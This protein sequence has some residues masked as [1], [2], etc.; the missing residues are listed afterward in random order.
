[1]GADELASLGRRPTRDIEAW[2]QFLKARDHLRNRKTIS[3]LNEALAHVAAAIERDPGFARAHSLRAVLLMLVPYWDGNS[4]RFETERGAQK[5]STADLQRQEA[6]WADALI[7]ANRALQLE[8]RLGEP[9]VVR[10]LF[11][12]RYNRYGDAD[13]DF[14]E[15]IARAPGNPDAH[16]WYGQFLLASGYLGQGLAEVQRAAEIDPLSPLIA[17]QAAFAGLMSGRFDAIDSYSALARENGWT[18]W[19]AMIIP[20][21]A[22]MARGDID[23]AE[24]IMLKALPQREKEIRM[25]IAA[26]RHRKIDKETRA[27]LAQ[28]TAYGPP[29]LARFAVETQAGDVDAAIATVFSTVD[30]DSLLTSDGSGG[31]ARPPKGDG[32]GSVIRADWWFPPAAGMRRDPRFAKFVSDIGLVKFWREHGWPDLCSPVADGVQCR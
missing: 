16:N 19:Q 30:Q 20:G 29:G 14:R 12:Q 11:A 21:G 3:D 18:G 10:A 9:Y 8:P 15:A 28:L 5:I 25:S 4:A 27:M 2:Q 32:P 7:A 22:A 24:K 26:V 23:L 13:R 1:M 6:H 31:P 17:W